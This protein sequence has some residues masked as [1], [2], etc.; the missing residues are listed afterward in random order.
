MAD[1]STLHWFFE[2]FVRVS[3]SDLC[4]VRSWLGTFLFHTL[5]SDALWWKGWK[6]F[7][8]GNK[9]KFFGLTLVRG[10]LEQHAG[11]PIPLKN[12]PVEWHSVLEQRLHI[13]CCRAGNTAPW[14]TLFCLPLLPGGL[15]L[16]SKAQNFQLAGKLMTHLIFLNL[17]KFWRS[18][19]LWFEKVCSLA[20]PPAGS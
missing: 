15:F 19:A 5:H 11:K 18:C 14:R 3:N 10:S 7:S 8:L 1:V 6:L 2:N 20:F 4:G 9:G 13:L 17:R 16:S 12:Q